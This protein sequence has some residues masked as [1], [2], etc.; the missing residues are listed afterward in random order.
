MLEL[1]K[2]TQE[3]TR[4]HARTHACT[5]TCTHTRRA[6]T[7]IKSHTITL[8]I[9]K[10]IKQPKSTLRRP[11][12]LGPA[13]CAGLRTLTPLARTWESICVTDLHGMVGYPCHSI[14]A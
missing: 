13:Q 6:V 11:L 12:A 1:E 5:L 3:H 10:N 9:K 7:Y 8:A 14:S 2:C 4:T